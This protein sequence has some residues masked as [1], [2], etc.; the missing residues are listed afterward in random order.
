M[1]TS[2]FFP[3]VYLHRTICTRPILLYIVK[4]KIFTI[5]F[6]SISIKRPFSDLDF[7]SKSVCRIFYSHWPAKRSRHPTLPLTR[8]L[9]I[10]LNFSRGERHSVL[11]RLPLVIPNS[12][13][14][15]TRV[16]MFGLLYDLRG[17]SFFRPSCSP[18]VLPVCFSKT[19]VICPHCAT[20]DR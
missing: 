11:V 6:L 5:F 8:D 3:P 20:D 14:L 13:G 9:T 2:I 17:S 4:R 7:P 15:W 18:I 10:L 1:C 19:N 12:A 16:L